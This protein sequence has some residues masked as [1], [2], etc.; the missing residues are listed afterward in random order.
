[1]IF[2]MALAATDAGTQRTGDIETG[3][4]QC[5]ASSCRYWLLCVWFLVSAPA[6]PSAFSCVLVEVYDVSVGSNIV[7][8]I[9]EQRN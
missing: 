5:I 1:M 8:A 7:G 6:A 2:A 9:F 4:Q 3:W